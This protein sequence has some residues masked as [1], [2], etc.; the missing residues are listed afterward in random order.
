MYRRRRCT[1][2]FGTLCLLSACANHTFAPGPGKS[3]L[4]YEPDAAKCRLFSRGANPDFAFA[5]SGSPR[6]VAGSTVGAA[7]GY[8]I[9]T[10]IRTNE[11]YNDC[12]ELNG[13]RVADDAPP[14][15]APIPDLSATDINVPVIAQPLVANLA[16][17]RPQSRR[18]FGIRAM[19]V[20]DELT[21]WLHMGS[22]QGLLVLEVAPDGAAAAAGIRPNDVL[23]TFADAPVAT[24]EDLLAA[25]ASVGP[26]S[27]VTAGVWRNGKEQPTR[28]EF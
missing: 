24:K 27:I 4:D 16:S 17:T 13:W 10:A 11:N 1:I 6:F 9:A 26:Q 20:P 25:L 22:A 23:L 5:A 15:P 18:L 21:G 19:Q 7:I 14:T 28:L 2:L 12:M 3:A 8:G